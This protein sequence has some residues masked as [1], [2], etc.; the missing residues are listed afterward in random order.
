M[1][2]FNSIECLHKEETGMFVI[3]YYPGKVAI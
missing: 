2:K 1:A 3:I